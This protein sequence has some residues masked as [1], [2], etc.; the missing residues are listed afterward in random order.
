MEKHP[1][2]TRSLEYDGMSM[3]DYVVDTYDYYV[4]TV[5]SVICCLLESECASGEGIPRSPP[6]LIVSF[7]MILLLL[8][9]ILLF[10]EILVGLEVH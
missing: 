4:S 10:P 2:K 8:L 3:D 5:A 7:S 9:F 6:P 1:I